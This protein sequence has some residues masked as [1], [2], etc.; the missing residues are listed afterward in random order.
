MK[1]KVIKGEEEVID[2]KQDERG[3]YHP[4]AVVKVGPSS[5][6]PNPYVVRNPIMGFFDG[7]SEGIRGLEQLMTSDRVI[8]GLSKLEQIFNFL[9]ASSN[10][11]RR[12]PNG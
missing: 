1:S 11:R 10:S 2:L 12:R 4:V 6:M 8:N 5:T 9:Q 7:F 3:V